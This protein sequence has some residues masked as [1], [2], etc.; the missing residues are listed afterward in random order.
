M[1]GSA[2]HLAMLRRRA[3]AGP[4][5]LALID[6]FMTV[7]ASWSQRDA[8]MAQR[9]LAAAAGAGMLVVAG[10][11][12]TQLT[13]TVGQDRP[14]AGKLQVQGGGRGG[15]CL[16]LQAR[17]DLPCFPDP[18]GVYRLPRAGPGRSGRTRG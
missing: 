4:L 18:P 16:G 17:D 11:A 7:A 2:G 8:A 5:R 3:A 1:G 9:V 10:N 6:P 13:S 12:H 15:G 14:R